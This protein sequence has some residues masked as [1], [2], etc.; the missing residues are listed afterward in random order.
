MLEWNKVTNGV[1]ENVSGF[2]L[3]DEITTIMG[4]SGAGKT[5]LLNSLY[6]GND[7]LLNKN[8]YNSGSIGYVQQN[9]YSFENLTVQELLIF[10]YILSDNQKYQENIEYMNLQNCKN[11]MMKHI[12]GGE[13]KRVALS[14]E[15]SRTHIKCLMFDEPTSGLDSYNANEFV[16]F[17]LSVL[18]GNIYMLSIHQPSTSMFMIFHKVI[19]MQN[20]RIV[21]IDCPQKLNNIEIMKNKPEYIPSHEYM[22]DSLVTS[23]IECLSVIEKPDDILYYEDVVKYNQKHNTWSVIKAIM[24]DSNR[25][26]ILFKAK[27]FQACIMSL[28]MGAIY[29]QTSEENIIGALFFATINQFFGATFGVINTFAKKSKIMLNDLPKQWYTSFEFFLGTNLAD[30]PGQF[31]ACLFFSTI[32][33]F[34]VGLKNYF[35]YFGTLFLINSTGTS[36]GY[37]FSALFFTMDEQVA[38]ISCNLTILPLLLLGG[39]FVDTETSDINELISVISPFKHGFNILLQQQGYEKEDESLIYM[40]SILIVCRFVAFIRISNIS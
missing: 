28:F 37:M 12:S 16:K 6:Q 29:W 32:S 1:L 23:T 9:N 36:F 34:M 26:P 14:I 39:F 22:L 11:V 24:I 7:C 19:F 27:I 4:P 20:G 21:Y 18:N 33:Y 38:L 5:T 25:E 10:Y 17:I 30:L 8:K 2:A 35:S 40:L 13:K 3:K 31:I 15:L